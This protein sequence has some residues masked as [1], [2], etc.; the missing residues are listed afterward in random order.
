MNYRNTPHP[1]TG[2]APAELVFSQTIKTKIPRRPRLL[3]EK[4]IE[5]ARANDEKMRLKRKE[6]FDGRKKTVEMEVKVRD[7][8]LV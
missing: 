6:E 3:G 4:E 2:K 1:A 5:E 8:V 7:T